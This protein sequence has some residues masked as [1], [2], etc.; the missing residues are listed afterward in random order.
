MTKKKRS[1]L[2]ALGAF[3]DEQRARDKKAEE[4]RHAAALEL[5]RAVLEAGG[6]ALPLAVIKTLIQ[7]AVRAAAP[8]SSPRQSER[9]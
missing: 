8:A 2:E 1:A 4:L 3:E 7:D 5:G 9:G 6:A